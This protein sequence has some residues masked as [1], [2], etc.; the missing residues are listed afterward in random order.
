VT[1]LNLADLRSRLYEAY[2]K[3]HPHRSG[4]E[5]RELVNPAQKNPT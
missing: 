4:D 1:S 3:K 5:G 2:V